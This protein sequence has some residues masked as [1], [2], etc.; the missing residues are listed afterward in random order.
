MTGIRIGN[1]SKT[2]IAIRITIRIN[3]ESE[4]RITIL[5]KTEIGTI[6]KTTIIL[7]TG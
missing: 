3:I 6:T 4:H 1:K 5:S 7:T 2:T